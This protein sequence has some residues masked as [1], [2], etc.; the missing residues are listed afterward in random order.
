M[1][2]GKKEKMG[3]KEK[4]NGMTMQ[5]KKILRAEVVI[6]IAIIA[7]IIMAN[8]LNTGT[9]ENE[10]H[11]KWSEPA[12]LNG[13]TFVCVTGSAYVKNIQENFP[14]SDII[15]VQDWADEDLSVV[16]KKADA[17]IKEESSVIAMKDEYPELCNMP[18][19]I[20]VLDSRMC[21]PKTE[22]GNRLVEELNE[23]IAALEESGEMEA[24]YEKWEYPD[25]APDHV[26]TPPME[27]QSKGVLR[28]VTVLDWPPLCY[29]NGK[30]ACGYL[31]DLTVRFCAKYG[32]EPEFDY[33]DYASALAGFEVGKYDL[34][35][36]GMV[37]REEA[38]EKMNFT[39]SLH[40]EPL[41]VV[42]H[43]DNYAYAEQGETVPAGENG[44]SAFVRKMQK[45]FIKNFVTE[46]R[47]RMLLSGLGVTVALS[48]LSGLFGTFLGALL[49]AM[50]RSKNS[51][52]VAFARIYIKL[53]Q[54]IPIMVLLMILY[55]IVFSKA[56]MGAFAV[57]VVGFSL[58]FAAYVSEIFRSGIEAIPAGQQRAAMALGFTRMQ[59]FRQVVLPQATVRILPV[60]I[61]QFISMVKMTSVAGYISVQDLTKMSDIIRSRTYEAFFPL[62]L[63]AIVYFMVAWILTLGLRIMK[64]KVDPATRSREVKGVTV[65]AAEG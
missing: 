2:D 6:I 24:L 41:Y 37:Y 36:Y 23:Y 60:Y 17:L 22:L 53:I 4:K 18:Q 29:Q 34:L 3:A 54:G 43:K 63:S 1:G 55:Y 59:S 9:G 61:G 25:E 49:C 62:I 31:I 65:N 57:C 40:G 42:I 28:V 33:M 58:D 21:T 38:S 5:E 46:D 26:E 7:A 52:A 51:Y 27:T 35:C 10:K 8:V 50:R 14:D 44:F 19:E 30:N 12:D 39:E 11:E 64:N 20:G 32:Y 47:W 15:Y 45:S 13:K 48:L 56:N 16:Y